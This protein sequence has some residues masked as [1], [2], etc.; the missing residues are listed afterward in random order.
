MRRELRS[1]ETGTRLKDLFSQHSDLLSSQTNQQ[2]HY[3]LVRVLKYLNGG[4]E[5]LRWIGV[6]GQCVMLYGVPLARKIDFIY[7]EKEAGGELTFHF[8]QRRLGKSLSSRILLPL[9][10]SLIASKNTAL[11]Q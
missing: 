8:G 9:Y 6:S 11:A 1:M 7:T 4:L 10:L 3:T 2:M 5:Y